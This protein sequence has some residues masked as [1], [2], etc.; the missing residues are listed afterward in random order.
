[1]P[2]SIHGLSD[3]ECIG[4]IYPKGSEK[5]YNTEKKSGHLLPAATQHFT[6]TVVIITLYQHLF[7]SY[8]GSQSSVLIVFPGK[9]TNFSISEN[10]NF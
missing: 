4:V 9:V 7:W 5:Y 6:P 2:P 1:M 10:N 3:T 8:I